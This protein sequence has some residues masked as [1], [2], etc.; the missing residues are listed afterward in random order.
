MQGWGQLVNQVILIISLLVFHH[1]SGN[2]PYSEARLSHS[3]VDC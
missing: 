3:Y 1:G 2:P